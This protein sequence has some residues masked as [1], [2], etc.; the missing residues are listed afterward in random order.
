MRR[1]ILSSGVVL[2]LPGCATNASGPSFN[3]FAAI[4]LA[5]AQDAVFVFRD[6][7]FYAAQAPYIVRS[8]IP[9]DNQPVGMVA[10]GGFIVA[11]VGLGWHYIVAASGAERTIRYFDA[12]PGRPVYIQIWDRTRM[13]GAR[14][15]AGAAG[16]AAGGAAAGGAS[17]LNADGTPADKRDVTQG[18]ASGAV[19]GAIVGGA[20]GFRGDGIYSTAGFPGETDGRLWAIEFDGGPTA[21]PILA[22][23][24]LS[25]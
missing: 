5:A 23:L 22:A 1:L 15:V 20:A 2:L 3:Q 14:A 10:N 16:G 4:P 13:E 19:T 9:I 24:R 11:N 17:A 8:T 18:A 12:L 7:V 25:Q 21:L 6:K